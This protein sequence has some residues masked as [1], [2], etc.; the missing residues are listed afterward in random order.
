MFCYFPFH[1]VLGFSFEISLRVSVLSVQS[2]IPESMKGLVD[3][4]VGHYDGD[5]TNDFQDSSGRLVCVTDS[6][7]TDRI[8]H[9]QFGETCMI[10]CLY[11]ILCIHAIYYCMIYC[12]YNI[13]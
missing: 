11:N 2:F 10:Y 7:C 1:C 12:L 9:E 5:I 6:N 13:L 8:I 4:L 3:G